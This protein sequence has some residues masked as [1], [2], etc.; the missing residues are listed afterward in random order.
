MDSIDSVGPAP[1]SSGTARILDA[2]PTHRHR[3]PDHHHIGSAQSGNFR[4]KVTH[5]ERDQ[6]MTQP[7]DGARCSTGGRR[8]IDILPDF[9]AIPLGAFGDTELPAPAY[10]NYERRKRPWVN[11]EGT[12]VKHH[13]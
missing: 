10:S 3:A 1:E 11:I 8:R 7:V 2:P 6:R 12:G 4:R 13:D 5:F 9:V